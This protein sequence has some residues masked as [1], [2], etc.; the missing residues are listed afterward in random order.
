MADMTAAST[1]TA[2]LPRIV[3][4]GAEASPG[5]LRATA[6]SSYGHFTAMQVRSRRVRGLDLH[7]DRLDAANRELFGAALD[8]GLVRDHVRRALGSDIADGSVRVTV[9]ESQPK[10]AVIV[11]VRPPGGMGAEV[12]KLR[13]VPYQR[14]V[15]HIKHASDFGQA[16]Y[17]RHAQAAGYDEALLTG[18][19][20]I[21]AEGSITNVG[22]F[23]GN[24][25]TWPAAPV[26]RGITM[27]LIAP[28]LAERGVPSRHAHVRLSD[29]PGFAAAFVT[30]SRGIAAVG[31]VDDLPL[32]AHQDLMQMLAAAYDSAT[33][34]DI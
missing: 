18:P 19:D 26:L 12:W 10:P 8:R 24:S 2:D 21:I 17:L 16:Y 27:Q 25:V 20:G 13:S 23:D 14:S 3:I 30:N 7:L 22:L 4:D 32:P 11:T 29:L 34:D 15:A 31:Q 9:I 33:W 28:R 5:Q 1:S 6:L